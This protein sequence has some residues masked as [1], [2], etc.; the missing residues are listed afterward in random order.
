[1]K[2]D[3]IAV[4]RYECEKD[5]GARKKSLK[6]ELQFVVDVI[7]SSSIPGNSYVCLRNK[8]LEGLDRKMVVN[9]E[10]G[11]WKLGDEQ[12]IE[13]FRLPGQINKF[14]VLQSKYPFARDN[15]IEFFE[16]DHR[17][18]VDGKIDVPR[19]VTTLVHQFAI[20]FDAD[21]I[22]RKMR[23]GR[24]WAIKEKEYTNAD[25]SVMT[26]QEIKDKWEKNR[27]VAS[28]RGT[29]MHWH[30]E[31]FLNGAKICGPFS[32]EFEYFLKF[33]K[34]FMLP[35]GLEPVRTELCVFHTGLVC[36]GQIDFLARYIGTDTYVIMDWKRSKEIKERNFFQNLL[37]PMHHLEQTNLN[38]YSL[39]LNLY[40]YIMQTEYD[41]KVD[42]L[43]LVVLHEIND[44]PL[45]FSVQIMDD[46]IERILRHEKEERNA[47]NPQSGAEAKFRTEHLKI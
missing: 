10:V 36:A 38:T 43:Y 18:V 13:T 3:A 2:K 9:G 27:V 23:N 1:M 14:D 25:G 26:D 44:K 5:I 17:Y 34:D 28:S 45:V 47:R 37:P 15:R 46:D 22:I 35:R 20:P 12:F 19:S 21:E 39:Q 30:I 42:E 16:K 33:Y 11:D 4:T 31:M 7:E 8:V 24:N 32:T 29:L 40:R 41:I 6:E